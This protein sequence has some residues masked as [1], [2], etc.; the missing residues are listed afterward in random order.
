[1][2][3]PKAKYQIDDTFKVTGRGVVFAGKILEGI[4][5]LGDLIEFEFNGESLRRKITGIEGIRSTP[6]KPNTGIL[7][8]CKDGSEIDELRSW[9]PDGTIVKVYD[10]K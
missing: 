8:E 9:N 2:N 6:E 3:E 1:M 5:N 7:I 4:I 10:G